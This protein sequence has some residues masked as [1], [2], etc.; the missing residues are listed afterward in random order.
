MKARILAVVVA[1]L[2]MWAG[3]RFADSHYRIADPGYPSDQLP[4]AHRDSAY[5]SST[6]VASPT[7]NYLQL[8]FFE[9]VEGGVCLRPSWADLVALKQA[10]GAPALPHLVPASPEVGRGK[11]D[12]LWPVDRPQPDPGTLNSSAYISLF[13]YGVLLNDMVMAAA[14]GATAKAAPRILIVGLGSGVGAAQLAHHFPDAAITVVDIDGVV[15]DMV[16]D[17]Y[18]LLR[19]LTTQV[20]TRKEPR[21][22]IAIADARRWI[23]YEAA[24]RK[25]AGAGFDLIILDAYTAGSTIPPHLMTRE[26]FASCAAG[27]APGGLVLANVI[28][29]HGKEVDGAIVGAMHRTLGGAIRSLRAAGLPECISIPVVYRSTD[30]LGQ[31]RAGANF[32]RNNIVI[33]GTSPLDVRR[34]RQGWERIANFV[35]FPELAVGAY[36]TANYLNAGENWNSSSV[37][38]AVIDGAAPGLARQLVADRQTDDASHHMRYSRSSDI[39]LIEQAQRAVQASTGLRLTGWDRPG[40]FLIRVDTDCVLL[41]REVSRLAQII[42]KDHDLTDGEALVGPLDPPGGER[43]R[44]AATWTIADAPLFT[45]Q[46]PNA[47]IWNR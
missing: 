7:D 23:R 3:Y 1:A 10:G 43:P 26:F 16:M 9:R 39:G 41:P 40:K 2:A 47:D 11:L 18:P 28:G 29:C 8:R 42:I 13:P 34:H 14:G 31:F 37:D 36:T 4:L 45:D 24:R 30:S 19:W 12:P 22:D 20:T 46:M 15:R 44:Q 5:T 17:H 21:L 38:A 35:H 27:L 6:W 32:T 25:A 33:A